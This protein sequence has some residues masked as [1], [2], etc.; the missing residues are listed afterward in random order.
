[1][2]LLELGKKIIRHDN[3]TQ[4]RPEITKKKYKHDLN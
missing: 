4:T 1:M 3:R 2:I